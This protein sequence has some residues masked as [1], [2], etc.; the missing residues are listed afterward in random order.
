[1]V[2]EMYWFHRRLNTSIDLRSLEER[3]L[4]KA[5]LKPRVFTNCRKCI[6]FTKAVELIGILDLDSPTLYVKVYNTSFAIQPSIITVKTSMKNE[7]NQLIDRF[8]G[9]H[10]S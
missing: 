5:K 9:E 3:L 4:F 10:I 6:R 1:M 8:L 2:V 7:A